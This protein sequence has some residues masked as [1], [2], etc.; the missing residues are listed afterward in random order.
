M[1]CPLLGLAAARAVDTSLAA[2]AMHLTASLTATA[3][4]R[5]GAQDAASQPASHFSMCPTATSSPAGCCNFP[6][7]DPTCLNP[8]PLPPTEKEPS[9]E[10]PEALRE[11]RGD[12]S[13]RKALMAFKKA[14]AEEQKKVD[15]RREVGA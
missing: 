6:L 12:D 13:N 9:W 2:W 10:L 7:N 5:A 8:E 3:V 4:K 14:Q 11:Y 15:R 1:R